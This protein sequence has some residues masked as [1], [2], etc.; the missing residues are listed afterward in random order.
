MAFEG[1]DPAFSTD[2]VVTVRYNQ[3]GLY[4]ARLIVGNDVGFDT[5]SFSILLM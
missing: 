5:L 4:D 3:S 1:G 2:S